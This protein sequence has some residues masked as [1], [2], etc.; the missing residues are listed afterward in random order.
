MTYTIIKFPLLLKMALLKKEVERTY[1][2]SKKSDLTKDR[3]VEEK[4]LV[5]ILTKKC[6]V[7]TDPWLCFIEPICGATIQLWKIPRIWTDD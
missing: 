1:Q 5:K 3:H 2:K 7:Q 6:Y 4:E